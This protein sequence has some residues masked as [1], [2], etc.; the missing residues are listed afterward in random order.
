MN[1]ARIAVL[2][3]PVSV[4]GVAGKTA[5]IELK[6]QRSETRARQNGTPSLALRSITDIN[7]AES[8]SEEQPPK[9]GKSANV[10]RHDVASQMTTQK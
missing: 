5:T 4:G 6:P 10:V 7:T 8:S 3:I 1:T 9:R 2:I